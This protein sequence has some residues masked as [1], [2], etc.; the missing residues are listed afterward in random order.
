M[1]S[2]RP[3]TRVALIGAGF[4]AQVH[5]A[6]LARNR[7]AAVVAVVDPMREKAQSLARRCGITRTHGDLGELLA[8]GGIDAAHVL[9]PPQHHA[10]VTEQLLAAGV[11]VLVEKPLALTSAAATELG[12]LAAERGLLLGTNHTLRFYPQVERLARELAQGRLG[13][14]EHLSV[15]LRVPLRQLETG[16]TT[17]PRF[18]SEAAIVFEQGVHP[19]ALLEAMLG[20]AVTVHATPSPARQLETGQRF[21]AGWQIAVRAERGTAQVQLEFGCTMP[22]LALAAYASDATVRIDLVRGTYT[23]SGKSRWLD[24]GDQ[25]VNALTQGLSLCGQGLLAPLRHGLALLRLL[26]PQDQFTRAMRR[27]IAAF[28]QALRAGRAAPCDPG[29]AARTLAYCEQTVASAGVQTT[30]YVPPPLPE[31]GAAR[32]GEVLVTGGT[33]FLG[34][35]LIPLLLTNGHPV[36]LLVRHAAKVPL[37]LR[38]P[39][40][41]FCVGDLTAPEV[42]DRALAGVRAV[43]HMATCAADSATA[44]EASMAAAVDA[45]GKAS[46]RHGVARFVFV[47][48]TAAL[49]L[50]ERFAVRGDATTDTQPLERPAYARGKIA[51]EKALAELVNLRGLRAV[52]L[53]P[54]I[55]VGEGGLLAP[56]GVGLW[57]RDNQCVGWGLGRQPLPFVLAQDVAA[58]IE[59]ALVAHGIDGKS[60]NLAGDVRLTAAEYVAT[61]AQRTGRRFRFW[62]QPLWLTWTIESAKEVLKLAGGRTPAWPSLHDLR[63]RA[64][65]AR[66]DCDDAKHDLGWW[67]CGDPERFVHEA[68]DVHVP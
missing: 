4:I 47:S 3:R 41:R 68:I 19:F 40:L 16:D 54:A 22:E 44:T 13:R 1:T 56:S 51:A 20:A 11:H 46:L 57:T 64:F 12:R 18:A 50:G 8:Q 38:D 2:P 25:A 67:P 23:R 37:R 34:R 43:V 60:Y 7:D 61:V 27:S 52:T 53:R 21:V 6:A 17:H 35:H 26:P 29:S 39:R 31:C 55:V 5:A 24:V 32:P 49:Y 14:L 42:L 65:R 45:L 48:S 10:A 33:G 28:H 30:A 9:V 59:K 62:P 63:S 66:L 15:V 58:A 36:T